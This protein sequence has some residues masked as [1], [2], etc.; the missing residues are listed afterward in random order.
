VE[1]ALIFTRPSFAVSAKIVRQQA[2]GEEDQ[3]I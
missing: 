3:F 2:N 1:E